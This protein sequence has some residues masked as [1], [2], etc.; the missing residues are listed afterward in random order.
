MSQTTAGRRL[1][2]TGTIT[3][4][5]AVVTRTNAV[6]TTGTTDEEGVVVE[7]GIGTV[8]ALPTATTAV[9]LLRT[10]CPSASVVA[11]VRQSGT[12]SCQST[13]T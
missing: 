4:V 13:S 3:V 6:G 2:T 8:S 10:L 1:E 12:K 7:T 5:E 11:S 9:R